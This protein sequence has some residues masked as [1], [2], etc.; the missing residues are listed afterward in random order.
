MALSAADDGRCAHIR[1]RSR[2]C[3]R[4][5]DSSR[6]RHRCRSAASASVSA[7]RSRSGANFSGGCR[8]AFAVPNT[9]ASAHTAARIDHHAAAE[10]DGTTPTTHVTHATTIT[11]ATEQWRQW[12]RS[13]VPF[14]CCVSA[15]GAQC[16]GEG[17]VGT[18]ART[19]AAAAAA[20]ATA[21][22]AAV[23]RRKHS[24]HHLLALA[25]S[26]RIPPELLCHRRVCHDGW[27]AAVCAPFSSS[28][29]G[30]AHAKPACQK[31][32]RRPHADVDALFYKFHY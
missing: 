3:V 31:P 28:H 20:A 11:G 1:C 4:A 2:C 24:V 7:G 15:F 9:A 29:P 8:D 19:S 6:Q 27:H 16:I 30:D 17:G 25:L 21:T 22:S 14:G 18:M 26:V 32:F 10:I 12:K 23:L 5:V 13:V